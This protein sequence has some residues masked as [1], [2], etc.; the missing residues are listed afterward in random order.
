[1]DV[2]LSGDLIVNVGL[3]FNFLMNILLSWD[4]LVD[5]GLSFN[6]LVKV[7][8]CKRVD[9]AS[10]VIRVHCNNSLG[11]IGDWGS[12]GVSKRG[13]TGIGQRGNTSV[14]VSTIV[15]NNLSIQGI[16]RCQELGGWGSRGCSKAS[17][18]SN[19]KNGKNNWSLPKYAQV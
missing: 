7:G 16:G 8:L 18:D 1:M 19:L 2:R 3:G 12:S 10:I 17:K 5:V 13:G 4:F 9:L 14:D 15:V 6:F 11:G